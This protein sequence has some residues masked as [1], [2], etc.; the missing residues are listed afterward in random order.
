MLILI[1]TERKIFVIKK[2]DKKNLDMLFSL[3]IS[4][5]CTLPNKICK[6]SLVDP[7]G[8]DPPLSAAKAGRNHL[9]K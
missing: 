6:I 5:D 3:K 2:E 9:N 8:A 4:K 7:Q 1:V